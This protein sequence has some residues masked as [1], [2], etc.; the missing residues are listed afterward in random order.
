MSD[1]VDLRKQ[2]ELDDLLAKGWR[3]EDLTW[4]P[5][6]NKPL[7]PMPD[8]LP[9][10]RVVHVLDPKTRR[11]NDKTETVTPEKARRDWDRR[12]EFEEKR[13]RGMWTIKH[14]A[15]IRRSRERVDEAFAA[16]RDAL[17]SRWPKEA[18]EVY[19]AM[20]RVSQRYELKLTDGDGKMLLD[21]VDE[22]AATLPPDA[23]EVV[24]LVKLS[25][26]GDPSNRERLM[27]AAAV[28]KAS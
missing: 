23:A 7:T 19:D 12:R 18:A 20:V 28:L 8:P 14:E 25:Y 5:P 6:N 9:T 17:A 22:I 21:R 27:Q 24:R 11:F 3:R 1:D 4:F 10:S 26:V 2:Q 16:G 15:V 13:A